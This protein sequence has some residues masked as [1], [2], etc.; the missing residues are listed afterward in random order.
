FF[1]ILEKLF[2]NPETAKEMPVIPTEEMSEESRP[3][4]GGRMELPWQ[5]VIPLAA[6]AL[7]VVG[8]GL[9]NSALV[10]DVLRITVE[11]VFL[12]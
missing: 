8:L 6:V 2:M 9:C 10:N 11:E 1:R 12:G 4:T 3:E 7:A 5:M